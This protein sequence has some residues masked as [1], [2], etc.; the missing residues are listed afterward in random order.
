M[1]GGRYIMCGFC[2]VGCM[3][4]GRY[5][6]LLC[7]TDYVMWALCRWAVCHVSVMSGVHYVMWV[8]CHVDVMS[9]GL[10][11]VGVMS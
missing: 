8:L 9:G 3:S 10:C 7:H 5:I 2:Q 6:R 4:G 11:Y 1:S